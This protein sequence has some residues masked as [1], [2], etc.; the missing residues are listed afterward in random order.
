MLPDPFYALQ[1]SFEPEKRA[2]LAPMGDRTGYIAVAIHGAD[3]ELD[4]LMNGRDLDVLHDNEPRNPILKCFRTT[5]LNREQEALRLSAD[6][7]HRRD[8]TCSLAKTSLAR[9]TDFESG[10]VVRHLALEPGACIGALNF[11]QVEKGRYDP[12]RTIE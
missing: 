7:H 1:F 2:V 10:N 11:E 3:D 5:F 8:L 6:M 9:L 12:R 4:R